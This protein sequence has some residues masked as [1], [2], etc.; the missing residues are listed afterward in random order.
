VANKQYGKNKK[1]QGSSMQPFVIV[2]GIAA[3]IAVATVVWSSTRSMSGAATQLVPIEYEDV[4]ELVAMATGIEQGDPDAE[5]LIMEFAD[6][7]CPACRQF[8]TTVKPQLKLAYL[9]TG[10]ARFVFHDFPLTGHPHSFLAAR[11]ARCA[12]DQGADNF[13]PYHDMLFQNQANWSPSAAPPT[14]AFA[15]YAEQIGLDRGEFSSCLN[16]DRHAETVSANYELGR[17]LG[18]GGTP[19]VYVSQGQGMAANVT[20]WSDFTAFQ[21]VIEEFQAANAPESGEE[22]N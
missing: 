13:W 4:N 19:T 14:G 8:A 11:A 7:Q 15:S 9:D 21:E 2:L 5:I 18:V 20:R 1:D 10:V 17:Q 16:S 6:F 22:G 3:L 12:M